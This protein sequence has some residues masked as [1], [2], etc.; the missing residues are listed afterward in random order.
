M[1][2]GPNSSYRRSSIYRTSILTPS[3]ILLWYQKPETRINLIL[4]RYGIQTWPQILYLLSPKFR[5]SAT[6]HTTSSFFNANANTQTPVGARTKA[7]QSPSSYFGTTDVSRSGTH[8]SRTLPTSEPLSSVV[9]A[10]FRHGN[11]RIRR[12]KSPLCQIELELKWE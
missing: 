2:K 8:R 10:H 3:R 12:W 9:T 6:F 4:L 1:P 5:I 7:V 11:Q